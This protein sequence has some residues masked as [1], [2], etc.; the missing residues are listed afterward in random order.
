M[1]SRAHDQAKG[2]RKPN[3]HELDS[4]YHLTKAHGDLISAVI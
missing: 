1:M 3:T 4:T 2:Y